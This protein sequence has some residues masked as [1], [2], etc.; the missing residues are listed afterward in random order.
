MS[1][2]TANKS[3]VEQPNGETDAASG[4][5][6]K[7]LIRFGIYILILAAILFASAGRLNWIMGWAYMGVY[8]TIIVASALVIPIDPEFVEERTQAKEGVKAWDKPLAIIGSV[9][10]PTAMLVVAGLDM[11]FGWSPQVPLALQ[12]AALVIAALGYLLSVWAMASNKFYSRFVRIQRDRGHTVISDGPY[13]YVRHPGYAGVIVFDLAT[14][15]ALSSL[16]TFIP[17][18]LFAL[19]LVVRTALEDRTLLEEL[20]GYQEYAARVRYRLLPGIW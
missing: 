10:F 16:W 17:S 1:A 14:A 9:L 20:D 4:M 13:R 8:G 11:R 2:N 7:A 19:L 6:L 18:V 15:P 3:A 5:R 12:I